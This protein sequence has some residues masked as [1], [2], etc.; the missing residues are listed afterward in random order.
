[1]KRTLFTVM[2]ALAVL[3][4][5]YSIAGA[6]D[7]PH[8]DYRPN[9]GGTGYYAGCSGAACHSV[10]GGVFL[11]QLLDTTA[12]PNPE[13]YANFCLT[14]HNAAGEAHNKSAGTPSNNVYHGSTTISGDSGV[15]HSWKGLNHNAGTRTPTSAGFATNR[16][17]TVTDGTMFMPGGKV[18]CQTCHDSMIKKAGIENIP[19]WINATLQSGTSYTFGSLS[20][21]Q[22]LGKYI[23]VYRSSGTTP[24]S[25]PTNTRTKNSY[26]VD[27]SE[28][29]YDY[30]NATVT[31]N[32][33]QTGNCIYVEIPQPYLRVDNTANAMC[34]DCHSDR[35]YSSV[36]HAPGTG[37]K[38]GHPVS[39]T[40]GNRSG[41][42][43]TIKPSATGNAYLES[44]SGSQKVLCTSCH[45]PHNAAS[46]NGQILRE[47][48]S[49][50]LC[51]DCHKTILGGYTSASQG[52]IVNIHNGSKHTSPT[53][54]LDCHTTHNSNN[55]L[56]I[57]NTI[58]G[59]NVNF[60]SFTGAR[61]FGPD[62]GYGICEVCHSATSHHL[63]NNSPSGQGHNTG[64]NCIQCHSHSNGFSPTG[65]SCD[66]CHGFPP[67]TIKGGPSGWADT[68]GGKHSVH[69]TYIRNKFG[70]GLTDTQVCGYCHGSTIPTSTHNT[71]K[72]SA[73]IDMSL[74][75]GGTFGDGGTIGKTNTA[76]DSC[77]TVACHSTT[78][79]RY[80]QDTVAGC[81]SCHEY[82][83]SAND[84][85]GTNG[86]T[87]RYTPGVVG[88]YNSS[89]Y[90]THLNVASAYNAATDTYAG[91]TGDVNKCG[92]CHPNTGTNHMD[93]FIELAPNG[94]GAGGG[95]F[96]ITIGKV[97]GTAVQCSNVVCHFSR[98]TPNWY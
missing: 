15:S 19:N 59:K 54:C 77:A 87:I 70:A 31:F 39:V 85:T 12:A 20:T 10:G 94:Y 8:A 56:M 66:S 79:T 37:A 95:N 76:D 65:G 16:A 64:T 48:D 53:Y 55:V 6:V 25:A 83:G 74:G 44:V 33:A 40:F 73:Y 46:K 68:V 82:P 92:K 81:D 45:D 30:S 58:N 75:G 52:V 35:I 2:I 67:S 24:I 43:N 27:P 51:S 63:S 47:A 98:T 9:A 49:Y 29:T 91:V 4:G 38:N 41:L 7:G 28:Y 80:W 61:S 50:T 3:T 90:V 17:G 89:L 84:W 42:N 97:T 71:G 18:N 60:Q 11:P 93:G 23:K 34:L 78:G 1:M 86:H 57:K 22:Y 13:D 72:S 69:M 14:C 32:T 26:L 36:S 5:A 96:N 62:T 21:K 88:T